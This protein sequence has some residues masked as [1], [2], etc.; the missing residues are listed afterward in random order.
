MPMLEPPCSGPCGPDADADLR[1]RHRR[2]PHGGHVVQRVARSHRAHHDA[3]RAGTGQHDDRCKAEPEDPAGRS[4]GLQPVLPMAR[5]LAYAVPGRSEHGSARDIIV[6]E[7]S[8]SREWPLLDSAADRLLPV[9]TPSGNHLLYVESSGGRRVSSRGQS[10]SG[11]QASRPSVLKREFVEPSGMGFF[12]D[13]TFAYSGWSGTSDVMVVEAAANGSFRGQSPRR[14]SHGSGAMMPAWSP[15]GRWLAWSEDNEIRVSRG[16]NA[17]VRAFRP[18]LNVQM[19][20][21]GHPS[22]GNWRSGTSVI[23]E[24]FSKSRTSRPERPAKFSDCLI[25][26]SMERGSW[27]GRGSRELL[28]DALSP[29]HITAVDIVTGERRQIHDTAPPKIIGGLTTSPPT[30]TRW[31]FVGRSIRRQFT[32]CHCIRAASH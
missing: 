25:P 19:I 3:I 28:I 23:L 18:E 4:D 14:V 10:T 30:D 17:V 1:T 26:N 21:R 31:R 9:W 13:E 8:M 29:R 6:H 20:Q 16:D 11:H 32:S 7:V 24:G 12:D 5:T 22:P 15:D 2:Y 27:R